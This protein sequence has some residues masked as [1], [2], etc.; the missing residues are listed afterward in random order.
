MT[1]TINRVVNRQS[2]WDLGRLVRWSANMKQ[3]LREMKAEEEAAADAQVICACGTIKA[4]HAPDCWARPMPPFPF[5][6]DGWKGGEK[7]WITKWKRV[8]DAEIRFDG[9]YSERPAP[10]S[11]FMRDQLRQMDREAKEKS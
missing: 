5:E 6:Q 8:P 11:G 7:Y 10:W 4:E 1:I 2:E 3:W 9:A